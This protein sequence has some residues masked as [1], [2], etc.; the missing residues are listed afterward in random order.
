GAGPRS[1]DGARQTHQAVVMWVSSAA[2]HTASSAASGHTIHCGSSSWAAE[3]AAGSRLP[4]PSGSGSNC[5]NSCVGSISTPPTVREAA[6][7]PEKAPS[8][9][10]ASLGQGG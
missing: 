8:T 1:T 7:I 10:L 4:T 2:A 6:L 9:P 5:A 3:T